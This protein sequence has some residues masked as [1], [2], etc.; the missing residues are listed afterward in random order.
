MRIAVDAMG[1]DHAPAV[2]I[3]GAIEAA[4]TG[5]CSIILVGDHEEISSV[6][7]RYNIKGLPVSVVH[8]SEIIRM[9]ESPAQ[10]CR[11]KKDASVLVATRMVKEGKADAVISAGNSGACLAASLLYL[12]RLKGVSRPALATQM[13][14]LKGHCIILDVGA[15]V[16]CKPKHLQQFAI[17][18]NVLAKHLMNI[19][20]PRIGLISIGEEEGKGDETTLKTYELLKDAHFNFVGNIEGGDIFRGMADVIVCDG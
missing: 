5:D 3:E 18:G 11:Q 8:A 13:P 16:D 14:T 7:R 1:G 19:S 6:L 9:D 17:M 2:P 12:G 10:G 20:S 4:R 15:N